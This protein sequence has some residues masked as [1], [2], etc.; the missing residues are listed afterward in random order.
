[1]TLNHTHL[2]KLLEDLI[3]AWVSDSS[4]SHSKSHETEEHFKKRKTLEFQAVLDRT[5][6]SVEEGIHLIFN[7]PNIE[8]TQKKEI[9][10]SF[11]QIDE[12][13]LDLKK[14]D[15][16]RTHLKIPDLFFEEGFR[17]GSDL[18]NTH[19]T[20]QAQSIFL[21]LTLIDSK[22]HL[23]PLCLGICL[24]DQNLHEEALLAYQQAFPLAQ[25]NSPIVLLFIVDSLKALQKTKEAKILC[26]EVLDSVNDL[27]EYQDI[28]LI[29]QNKL[30]T[31]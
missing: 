3:E 7:S 1:M 22:N 24:A 5:R 14:E 18:L 17:L 13:S 9:L 19:Q 6:L 20:S 2:P 28:K 25:N 16:L 23:F 31:L 15:S 29:A 10:S 21:A 27:K 30:K 26:Q 4:F 11:E 8:E 12:R